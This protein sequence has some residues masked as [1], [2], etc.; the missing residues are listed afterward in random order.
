MN[1]SKGHPF[2]HN[3]SISS[4]HGTSGLKSNGKRS[5]FLQAFPDRFGAGMTVVFTPQEAPETG[6][7]PHLLAQRR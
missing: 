1:P 4:I 3:S 7:Q 2:T 6:D 5:H